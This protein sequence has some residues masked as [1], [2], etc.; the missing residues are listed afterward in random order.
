VSKRILAGLANRCLRALG[1]EL[2]SSFEIGR[3]RDAWRRRALRAADPLPEPPLPGNAAEYLRDDNPR[4]NELRRR[5]AAVSH[6][7]A[8]RSLW[9]PDHVSS[10]V[11]L[12]R[13]RSDSAFVWQSRSDDYREVNYV[14]TASY[15]RSID[16][17][18]LLER[19]ED[20]GLFGAVVF[21]LDGKRVSRESL[22]VVSELT[23]LEETL[24]ISHWEGT[25][26][27]VGAGYGRLAYGIA[28]AL[29][30]LRSLCADAVPEATFLSEYYLRFRGVDDAATAVPLDE[31]E[32]ALSKSPVR[33]ATNVHSFSEA[34]LRA[35]RWWVALLARN[36]V[37]YL[38]IAPNPDGSDG[39]RLVSRENDG[40][41][42]EWESVLV[43][44]GYSLAVRRPKYSPPSI[45]RH[46]LAPTHYHLFE[47]TPP[48]PDADPV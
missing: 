40:T 25:V 47:L 14:L 1:A 19:L 24:G 44:H 48:D 21:D 22:D 23:F 18:G 15:L 6:D 42:L 30:R 34:P 3:L 37:R 10:G 9:S 11:E 39:R 35:I 27:D 29:P 28:R 16:R 26:L 7:G 17:L 20:D 33:L 43:E 31:I 46:A 41:A 13:F 2:V 45:Q 8:A 36:R 12:R 32:V 4:L 5:Y 38:M